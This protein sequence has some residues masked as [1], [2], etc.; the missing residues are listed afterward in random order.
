MR[1]EGVVQ[2]VGLRPWLARRALALDLE[3][4]VANDTAGVRLVLAGAREA[5]DAVLGALE[6]EPPAGARIESVRVRLRAGEAPA[7]RGTGFRIRAGE[8]ATDASRTR[9]PPDVPLCEPCLDELFDPGNRRH[10]H[11]FTHCASCGPRSA[12]LIAPPWERANT[13]LA[14]FA[15]CARCR[16]EFDDPADRRFHAESIACPDCGPRLVAQRPEGARLSGDPVER[17]ADALA[18]GE[19]V[20]VKSYA[21]WHLAVLATDEAAV[22]RLRIRKQRPGKP[23]ALLVPNLAAATKLAR[24]GDAAASAL[25]G[26]ARPVVLAPRCEAGCAAIGLA[27]SVAPGLRDL[28]LLLPVAPLHHL[29]FWSPGVRP[30]SGAPRFAALVLTSANRS[31]EPTIADDACAFERLAGVADLFL[32]H[33]RAIVRP[34]DDGVVRTTPN[35]VIPI[36]LARG[37]APLALALP[38]RLAGAL[39][40]RGAL[41][42]IGGDLANAPAVAVGGEVWLGAHVGDLATLAASEACEARLADLARLTASVPV[43][44]AHDAH[45]DYAG[46][47]LAGRLARTGDLPQFSIAH[48]H[49]H[50]A[51]LLLE[52]GVEADESVIALALDGTGFGGDGTVWG[53]ELLEVSFARCERLGHLEQVPLAGGDAAAREPWRMAAVWL[54]RAF[55]GERVPRLAWHARRDEQALRVVMQAAQ[56]NVNAPLTSSCGRLFDAVSSLLDRVDVNRWDGHAASAL[57][58]L[59]AGYEEAD[60]GTAPGRDPVAPL[61]GERDEALHSLTGAV[62]PER[63]AAADLVRE[64]VRARLRGERDSHIARWFH[65]AL[66]DRLADAAARAAQRCG[67][68]RIALAGGCFQNR[69]LLARIED[70]LAA[71]GWSVLVPRRLPPGDGALAAG[72]AVVAL[73]RWRRDERPPVRIR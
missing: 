19:I 23:F 40:A 50:A 72:Q 20:A 5:I 9:L 36:R 2:G 73:A 24:L 57:E 67:C 43:A 7:W 15:L 51:A 52:H 30:G 28:G 22:A 3:G 41:F 26:A 11:P 25:C 48:H 16:A 29:L 33:D 21:G 13:T 32:A 55:E 31:G 54:A 63:I 59:A 17:A 10:R 49:A 69:R 61:P 35:G 70:R 6:H 65:H 58:A 45:P 47:A 42:A 46:T 37:V 1:I 18:R 14:G 62:V 64:V 44:I 68:R 60:G 8:E 34:L 27:E 39:P 38:R 4:E 12:V 71:A 66:A 53:G 56:R